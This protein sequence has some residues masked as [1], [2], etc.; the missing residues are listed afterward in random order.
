[1]K[2][3]IRKTVEEHF[4]KEKK[5]K[6]KGIKVLSLFFIDRVANYRNYDQDG[7]PQKGKFAE[8]F[9]EAYR[10]VSGKETYKGLFPFEMNEMHNGY[11]SQDNKGKWKDTTGKSDADNDTFKLIMKKRQEIGRVL[12]LPVDMSGNRIQDITINRLTVVANE[13]YDDF[14]RQLQSEIEEDCGVSFKGRIKNKHDR[15]TVKY[16]KGFEL[17]ECSSP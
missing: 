7:Q 15:E 16:R 13:S 4:Q 14:A 5:L 10:E 3:Q 6:S 1:M 17:D 11:F 9:E 2:V 8:W 12:R